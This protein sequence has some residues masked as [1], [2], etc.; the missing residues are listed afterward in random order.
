MNPL[1]ALGA[2]GSLLGGLFK[3]ADE[4]FTTEEERDSAKLKILELQAAGALAQLEVN[5]AEASTGNTYIAGWRPFV[6]WVCG[7]AFAWQFVAQPIFTSIIIYIAGVTGAEVDLSGIPVIPM[8]DLMP[9]LMGMLGLGY[10]RT[11]EKKAGV[12]K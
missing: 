8:V 2:N 5:K 3:I 10:L 11:E 9:V 6:G 7:F 4:L 1:T 12:S